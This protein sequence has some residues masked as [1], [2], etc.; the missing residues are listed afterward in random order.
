M[1]IYI[2]IYTYTPITSLTLDGRP[3]DD[4]SEQRLG[5]DAKPVV[6][7]LLGPG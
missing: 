4:L 5:A 1:Y 2:Y 3:C 7:R 6:Q